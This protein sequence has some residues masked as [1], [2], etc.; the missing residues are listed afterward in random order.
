MHSIEDPPD[1]QKC[2]IVSWLARQRPV[3]RHEA[4][5]G[6]LEQ[7]VVLRVE[8]Q[9]AG[10]LHRPQQVAV[11]VC[12]RELGVRLVYDDPH[13]IYVRWG[14]RKVTVHH[15]LSRPAREKRAATHQSQPSAGQGRFKLSALGQTT[16]YPPTLLYPPLPSSHP[17]HCTALRPSITL[18]SVRWLWLFGQNV[19]QYPDRTCAA[20][21]WQE[22]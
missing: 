11:S 18:Q 22:R 5:T 8:L 4:V 12:P 6:L 20:S 19:V 1:C 2:N 21:V 13:G 17:L 9:H 15:Q 3:P 7:F 10:D 16:L 14:G